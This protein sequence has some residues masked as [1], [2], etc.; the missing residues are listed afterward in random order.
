MRQTGCAEAIVSA[1]K[2]GIPRKLSDFLLLARE[3]ESY[4]VITHLL[5]IFRVLSYFLLRYFAQHGQSVDIEMLCRQSRQLP[6]D[7]RV[8]RRPRADPDATW[9]NAV[10]SGNAGTT[11]R[12]RCPECGLSC[13]L[14]LSTAGAVRT[15]SSS[16]GE[17]SFVLGY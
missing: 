16:A 8:L 2:S 11:R 3:E 9:A 12:L 5:R 17:T 6:R 13:R 14:C 1:H 4:E 10:G 7:L 15:R